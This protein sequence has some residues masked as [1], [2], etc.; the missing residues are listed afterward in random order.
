M[1]CDSELLVT[2]AFIS[3][4]TLTDHL[5]AHQL[6]GRGDNRRDYHL[7]DFGFTEG[8]Y[9]A[10]KPYVGILFIERSG[11][12]NKVKVF[13]LFNIRLVCIFQI[14]T[15]LLQHGRIDQHAVVRHRDVRTCAVSALSFF[16]FWRFHMTEEKSNPPDFT[17][18]TSWYSRTL[19]CS[20]N[21]PLEPISYPQQYACLKAE[22]EK[23][24]ILCS[25]VTHASRA[26]GPQIAELAGYIPH[27]VQ[28]F[29]CGLFAE[30]FICYY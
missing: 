25:K 14:L 28:I 13:H 24:G 18:R 2:Q 16:L 30:N 17:S 1:T 6:F 23:A 3:L 5:T 9:K 22:F 26:V 19:F 10:A 15:I 12:A 20:K 29:Q 11:K 21:R 8:K 7:C 27:Y 4:R